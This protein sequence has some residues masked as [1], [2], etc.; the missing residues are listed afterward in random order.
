MEMLP[1]FIYLAGIVDQINVSMVI[2]STLLAVILALSYIY[3]HDQEYNRG[4][5]SERDIEILRSR[6]KLWKK[7]LVGLIICGTIGLLSPNDKTMYAIAGTYGAV[8]I[9]QSPESK[10]L[11][12]K[13]FKVI[14]QKLDEMLESGK[15][16]ENK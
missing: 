6:W 14:N 3:L 12:E 5:S 8:Q 11:V 16:K 4:V 9:A 10:V 1:L 15:S 13:S 2:V 7:G